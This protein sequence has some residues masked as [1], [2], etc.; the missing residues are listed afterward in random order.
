MIYLP[1]E[2]IC[3]PMKNGSSF[4][5]NA[6]NNRTDI[7]TMHNNKNHRL[8]RKW[9]INRNCMCFVLDT[10]W[11][12]V[13]HKTRLFQFNGNKLSI[14]KENHVTHFGSGLF[15]ILSKQRW[16]L[17]AVI[18]WFLVPVHVKMIASLSIYCTASIEIW[19]FG[20]AWWSHTYHSLTLE[21]NDITRTN[22]RCMSSMNGL[23]FLAQWQ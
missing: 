22:D 13:Q 9:S 10:K 3:V 14:Q 5:W 11:S 19:N 17:D 23:F 1:T 15:S 16:T 18:V 21:H 7:I 4:D 6:N 20:T 12:N 2:R 8:R